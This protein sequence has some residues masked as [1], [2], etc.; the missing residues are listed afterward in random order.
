MEQNIEIVSEKSEDKLSIVTSKSGDDAQKAEMEELKHQSDIRM[1]LHSYESECK[2]YNL[3]KV[4]VIQKCIRENAGADV[5]NLDN[6]CIGTLQCRIMF[7][8]FAKNPATPMTLITMKNNHIEHFCCHSISTFIQL[9]TTLK[10][11]N[12]EGCKYDKKSFLLI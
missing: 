9:S 10:Q 12:L 2:R 7:D 6:Y 3:E 8:A 11:L 1:K 4:E 5:C